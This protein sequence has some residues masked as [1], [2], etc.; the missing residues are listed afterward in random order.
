MNK[1]D[2]VLWKFRIRLGLGSGSCST[3]GGP[4]DWGFLKEGMCGPGSSRYPIGLHWISLLKPLQ[5]KCKF[6]VSLER[7]C[8]SSNVNLHIL[9]LVFG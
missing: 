3:W 7:Q 5:I 2:Q 4:V 6:M 8:L 9:Q 1:T